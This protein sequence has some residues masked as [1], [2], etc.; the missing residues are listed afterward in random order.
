MV[1]LG[2]LVRSPRT[3]KPFGYGPRG[4]AHSILEGG[5]WWLPPS[6]GRGKSCESELLVVRPSTK[7]V[8]TMH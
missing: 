3:K 4:E 7:S 8:P 6:S 1:I 2:L 5:R